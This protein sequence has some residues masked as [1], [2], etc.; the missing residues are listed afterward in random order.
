MTECTQNNDVEGI[1]SL[2]ETAE[3]SK[4]PLRK[5]IQAALENYF[6]H[7]DKNMPPQTVY[8]MVMDEVEIPLLKTTLHYAKDN[9]CLAAKILGI[10]RSTL[11]KKLQQHH[12]LDH[13]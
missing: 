12:L 1:L 3:T 10:S 7:I 8:K 5:L 11:R 9:Q 6:A 13:A 4:K 2:S